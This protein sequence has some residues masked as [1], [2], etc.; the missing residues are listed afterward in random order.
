MTAARLAGDE[1]L[2][3]EVAAGR[4]ARYDDVAGAAGL[5]KQGAV[6][7][8]DVLERGRVGVLGREPVVDRHGPHARLAGQAGR[9]PRGCSRGAKREAAA[10]N[11]ED[12]AARLDVGYVDEDHGDAAQVCGRHADVCRQGLRGEH[13]LEEGALGGDVPAEVERGVA[14]DLVDHVAL[15]GGHCRSFR[16]GEPGRG[17]P[18]AGC[19][20]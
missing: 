11:V 5:L 2:D 10:V 8:R 7:G 9:Q 17:V 19:T 4:L 20:I 15:L 1:E 3:G 18:V 16:R 6:G 13:L 12:S 14:E